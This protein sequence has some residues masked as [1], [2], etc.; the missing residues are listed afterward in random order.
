MPSQISHL[1]LSSFV[2]ERPLETR[3]GGS[4]VVGGVAS[5]EDEEDAAAVAAEDNDV[6]AAA[7]E[8][9]SMIEADEAAR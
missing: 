4:N 7:A 6:A 1:Y 8:A 3:G 9:L 5:E 2:R